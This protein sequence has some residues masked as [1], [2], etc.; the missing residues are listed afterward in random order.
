MINSIF[1]IVF[2]AQLFWIG[3]VGRVFHAPV[4]SS[5]CGGY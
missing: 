5:G 2:L 4:T 1:Q 3:T